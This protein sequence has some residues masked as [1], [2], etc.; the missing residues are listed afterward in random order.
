MTTTSNVFI[1]VEYFKL[2][3]ENS[4]FVVGYPAM[5][6]PTFGSCM[7]A[8]IESETGSC[9]HSNSLRTRHLCGEFLIV[10]F[11]RRDAENAET[12]QRKLEV[13]TLLETAGS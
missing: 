10:L 3:E 1:G 9:P 11:H 12:S 2:C 8:E 4:R 6:V 13:R 5:W 7:R